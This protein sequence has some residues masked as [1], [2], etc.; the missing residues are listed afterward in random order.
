[1]TDNPIVPDQPSGFGIA[2]WF[3]IVPLFT[4]AFVLLMGWVR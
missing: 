1:M 4:V 2:F 3:I